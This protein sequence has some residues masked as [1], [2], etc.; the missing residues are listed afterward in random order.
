MFDNLP[1]RIYHARVLAIPKSIG[2]GQ[3]AASGTLAKTGALG[4]ATGFPAVIPI[5]DDMNRDSLRLGM[6]GSATA[7]SPKAGVICR[8]ASILMW[9]ALTPRT[10]SNA[11]VSAGSSGRMSCGATKLVPIGVTELSDFA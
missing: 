8:L 9:S 10:C 2:Q 6:S 1:G 5:P 7:F 11:P 4:G 3:I